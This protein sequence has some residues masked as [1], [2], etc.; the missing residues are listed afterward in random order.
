M[1]ALTLLLMQQNGEYCLSL[2]FR[3]WL[4]SINIMQ[5]NA[6]FALSDFKY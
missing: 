1:V 6:K 4:H 2:R 3:T 5:S